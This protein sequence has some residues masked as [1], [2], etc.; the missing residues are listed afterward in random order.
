MRPEGLR[1]GRGGNSARTG[2]ERF[3]ITWPRSWSGWDSINRTSL[4][5]SRFR[6]V[7]GCLDSH[8]AAYLLVQEVRCYGDLRLDSG[9]NATRTTRT[10]SLRQLAMPSRFRNQA[11][12]I[13]A[14]SRR[15]AIGI[16]LVLG[17]AAEEPRWRERPPGAWPR[18]PATSRAPWACSLVEMARPRTTR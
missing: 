4:W 17:S 3:G 9:A 15:A 7:C 11:A 6:R 10:V 14:F 2:A 5:V 12:L 18:D 16:D 1:I 8:T 13:V